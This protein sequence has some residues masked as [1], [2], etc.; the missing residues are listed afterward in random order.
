[1]HA[2]SPLLGED[3]EKVLRGVLGYSVQR[4]EALARA[5]VA[6]MAATARAGA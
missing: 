2:P 4:I 3:T 6:P 5:G 1:V